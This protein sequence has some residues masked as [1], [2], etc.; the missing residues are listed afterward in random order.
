FDLNT[1]P[2]DAR[3]AAS[4]H[5]FN[6]KLPV[7]MAIVFTLLSAGLFA[8]LFFP[9]KHRQ[10]PKLRPD[11][12][13]GAKALGYL[14][15]PIF[16][17]YWFVVMWSRLAQRLNFQLRLRNRPAIVSP[18]LV[19]AGPIAVLATGL[20]FR[21]SLVGTICFLINWLV[22]TPLIAIQVESAV[23]AIFKADQ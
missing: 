18:L 14:F 13:G 19:T 8:Y 11:D 9:L 1:L 12:P 10:L 7:W 4:H 22:L 15:I 2:A 20:L 6:G 23:S 16:N 17:I 21:G 3:T 5:T